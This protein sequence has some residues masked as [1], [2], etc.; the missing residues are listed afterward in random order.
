MTLGKHSRG[1]NCKR[2]GCLK[3][4]CECYQANVRCSENC[5]CRDCKNFEGSDELDMSGYLD[6]LQARKI[7]AASHSVADRGSSAVPPLVQDQTVN[8]FVFDVMIL[9]LFSFT[10]CV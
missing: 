1:C 10:L 8:P 6:L 2:S 3:K 4:Y 5:R 9:M 7:K